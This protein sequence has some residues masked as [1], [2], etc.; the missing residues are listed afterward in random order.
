[1]T[2]YCPYCWYESREPSDICPRCGRDLT[3]LKDLDYPDRLAL[4]LVHPE[5]ETRY[6]AAHILGLLKATAAIPA[7]IRAAK[8]E[9]NDIFLLKEIAWALGEMKESAS[10]KP[11]LNLLNHPSFIIRKEAVKALGKLDDE[12]IIPGLTRALTDPIESVREA[13]EEIL[14]A[15]EGKGSG[16][17]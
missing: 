10:L 5:P 17:E 3:R 1:M 2:Y 12:S 15:K 6:R 14:M 11:L 9:N 13:A 4:S 16:P 7:F 8:E